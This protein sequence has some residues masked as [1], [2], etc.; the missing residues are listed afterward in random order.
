[1]DA[2]AVGRASARKSFST[3]FAISSIF[4]IV[5]EGII[6]DNIYTLNHNEDKNRDVFLQSV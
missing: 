1:M 2:V 3:S 4:T 6:Q 5:G